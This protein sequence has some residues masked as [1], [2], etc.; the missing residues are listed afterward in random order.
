MNEDDDDLRWWQ[1]VGQHEQDA[2][3]YQYDMAIQT[4]RDFG[5]DCRALGCDVMISKLIEFLLSN[6]QMSLKWFEKKGDSYVTI[7]DPFKH[8][9]LLKALGDAF[10]MVREERKKIS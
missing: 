3:A 8:D 2:E 4:V 6:D 7:S 10:V 9:A 1:E 5:Y